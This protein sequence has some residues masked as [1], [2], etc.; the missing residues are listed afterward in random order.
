[1]ILEAAGGGILSA[2]AAMTVRF[3]LLLCLLCAAAPARA[4]CAREDVQFYL[5]KGFTNEQVTKLCAPAAGAARPEAGRYQAYADEYVDRKDEEYTTRMRVEREVFLRNSI[6]ATD[7]RVD[8]G[9]LYFIRENCVSEGVEKDRAFGL[10]AC[11]EVQFRIRLA[12]LEVHEKEY[13]RRFLFGLPLIQVTGEIERRALP[14]GFDHI[15]NEYNRKLLRAKLER[16]P[17]TKIP[18]RRGV[19]FHFAR[20][21]LQDI[22][23]FETRR[24]AR[25]AEEADGPAADEP[26]AGVGE[27][28]N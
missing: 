1:M 26:L 6:E 18:L 8:G 17:T 14:G 4:E 15:P 7:I 16:G 22:V 3:P 20:T 11:P 28:L 2:R 23:D 10:K 27:L 25:R 9:R 19:D 12:G 21:A 5:D 13:K 24:A